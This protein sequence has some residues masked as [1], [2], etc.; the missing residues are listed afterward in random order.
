M[1][2]KLQIKQNVFLMINREDKGHMR[3]VGVILLFPVN[4]EVLIYLRQ[5]LNGGTG[6]KLCIALV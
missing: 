4:W 5:R 6:E 1:N 2:V 3:A